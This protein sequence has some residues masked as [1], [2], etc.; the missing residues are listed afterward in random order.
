[1]NDAPSIQGPSQRL[2]AAGSRSTPRLASIDVLRAAAI[3]VMVVVHFVENLSGAYDGG[4]G[5]FV[6]VHHAWWLPTG[7]AAPTFALLSGVSYRLWLEGQWRR[8]VPD[9][10]ISRRTLRRGCFLVVLGLVF[11]VAIWLPEDIFNWDILTLIGV[12]LLALDAARRMPTALVLAAAGATVAIAP[13]LRTLADYPASWTAG[14]FDYDFTVADVVLGWLVTG[15]FPVFPWLAY[16]LTG[17]AVAGSLLPGAVAPGP[18]PVLP[19]A[20][21]RGASA[22]GVAVAAGLVVAAS[23][24]RVWTMFPASTA[25]VLGTLGGVSLAI[26]ALHWWIDGQSGRWPTLVAWATPLSRHAL[27]IYLLHHAVHI[28]PLWLWSLATTGEPTA[29]WQVA[30]PPAVSLALAIVFLAVAAVLFRQID[31]RRWPAAESLMRSWCD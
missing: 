14:Y 3:A 6:G 20:V 8:S 12:G 25:Y 29:L 28:W 19:P 30:L 31:R 4:S 26:A 15:Y 5:R 9:S 27:S 18:D 1:V 17:F 11:N 7:F 13:V 23:E 10:M 2:P 22:V 24:R 16:P 21:V